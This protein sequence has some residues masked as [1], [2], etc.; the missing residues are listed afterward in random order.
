MDRPTVPSTAAGAGPASTITVHELRRI[1][2][3]VAPDKL[4]LY[5][6]GRVM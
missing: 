2:S 4:P 6:L 3:I 1:G 5:E